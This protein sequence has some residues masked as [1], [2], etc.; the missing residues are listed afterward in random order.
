MNWT[1]QEI[2]KYCKY[3]GRT[4]GLDFDCPVK[5]NGRLTKTLGRVVAEPY[6]FGYKP[7]SLEISRKV[8]DHA[9]D[10]DIKAVIA[11]EFC[12]WAVLIET[13]ECHHHDAIFKA[14]CRRIGCENDGTT[15]TVNY[16]VDEDTLYKY[17]VRCIECG[18]TIVFSR[19]GEVVKKPD[20]YE[21]GKCGGALEVIQNW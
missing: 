17:N 11:H 3:L 2:E 10:E 9:T 16:D 18:S 13:Q 1:V 12:H 4:A 19:A 6:P 7:C 21:C 5:I 8:I 14:M 20:E 15:I